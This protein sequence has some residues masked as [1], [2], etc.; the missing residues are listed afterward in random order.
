MTKAFL[1][2]CVCAAALLVGAWCG[3]TAHASPMPKE[4]QWWEKT[5]VTPVAKELATRAN[6]KKFYK[7]LAYHVPKMRACRGMGL[8][9][10]L[11]RIGAM[12]QG[13]DKFLRKLVVNYKGSLWWPDGS[14]C[15]VATIMVYGKNLDNLR[16]FIGKQLRRLK[17][18]AVRIDAYFKKIVVDHGG[19]LIDRNWNKH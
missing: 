18:S 9:Y 17:P 15:W 11:P 5:E 7:L 4:L 19:P 8:A 16:A 12:R 6:L 13:I 2:G 1:Y 3:S 14:L 10:C